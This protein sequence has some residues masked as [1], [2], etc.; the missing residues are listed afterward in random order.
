[1]TIHLLADVLA[2]LYRYHPDFV[3]LVTDELLES[4]T[5]GLETN[6]ERFHQ[7]RIAEAKYLCELYLSRI[8]DSAVIF[9]TMYLILGFGYRT[10]L[11]LHW[12]DKISD[13][14]PQRIGCLGLTLRTPSILLKTHSASD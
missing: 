6:A 11:D 9:E 12:K 14:S 3:L 10:F 7:R 5:Q 1:M 8:I 4:I 13:Y 2:A